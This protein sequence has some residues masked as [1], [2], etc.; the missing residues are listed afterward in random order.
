[1][2]PWEASIREMRQY[3]GCE[4]QMTSFVMMIVSKQTVGYGMFDHACF[5]SLWTQEVSRRHEF[6]TAD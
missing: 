3:T 6:G 5:S 4:I 2:R 1:M